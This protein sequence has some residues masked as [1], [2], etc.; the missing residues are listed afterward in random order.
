MKS[1]DTITIEWFA[2]STA[3]APITAGTGQAS[4]KGLAGAQAGKTW[5]GAAW[6]AGAAV[7]VLPYDRE[8]RFAVESALGTPGAGLYSIHGKGSSGD[9]T[10]GFG[11]GYS[12]TLEVNNAADAVAA[13]NAAAMN[14]STLT[15]LNQAAVVIV[16]GTPGF[17]TAGVNLAPGQSIAASNM[18]AAA[19]TAAAIALLIAGNTAGSLGAGIAGIQTG[20]NSL[21][22]GITNLQTQGTVGGFVSS[23]MVAAAPTAASIALLIAGNTA[24]TLGAGIS[25]NG[26]KGDSM[27]AAL[28]VF[29]GGVGENAPAIRERTAADLAYLGV[30]L[31]PAAN[32][33]VRGDGEITAAGAPVRTL[34]IGAR[35]DLEIAR[36]VRE[37]LGLP[38]AT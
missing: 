5:N 13:A 1:G 24:G 33:A 31:D 29:T 11:Y 20:T 34:V 18:V 17:G 36:E 32:A 19:P 37:V 25:N 7:I 6:T 14:G 10:A 27:I 9:A 3:G 38:G 22:A 2:D 15:N 12:F 23:N 16:A 8:N 30:R 28:G 4:V 35:E 21:G 26:T